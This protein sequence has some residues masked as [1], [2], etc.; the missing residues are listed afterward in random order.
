MYQQTQ[1]KSLN[2]KK[3]L[4]GYQNNTSRIGCEVESEVTS[5]GKIQMEINDK[6]FEKQRAMVSCTFNVFAQ[7]FSIW[8]LTPIYIQLQQTKAARL[9]D[10]L[11]KYAS[12][13]PSNILS[14]EE[15]QFNAENNIASIEKRMKTLLD[16]VSGLRI[17][18]QQLDEV[19]RRVYVLANDIDVK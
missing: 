7:L 19:F 15:E 8:V 9:H 12:L 17:Q 5:I 3:R 1:S 4:E 13:G 10:L 18:H 6:L 11:K 14:Q 2:V 16:A